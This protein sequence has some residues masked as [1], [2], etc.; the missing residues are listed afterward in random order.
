MGPMHGL[1]G[2]GMMGCEAASGAP[3]PMM[4]GPMMSGR[5]VKRA[6]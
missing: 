4:D 3:G 5:L 1:W 6:R 2:A